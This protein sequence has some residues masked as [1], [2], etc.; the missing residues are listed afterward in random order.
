MLKLFSNSEVRIY[1]DLFSQTVLKIRVLCSFETSVTAYQPRQ[2][3][4][5]DDFSLQQKMSDRKKGVLSEVSR[6]NRAIKK[7]A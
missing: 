7:S 5:P 2:R 3:N 4:N 1:V 6:T